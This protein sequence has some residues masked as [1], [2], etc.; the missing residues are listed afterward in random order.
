MRFL[1]AS[2]TTL[3]TV[4]IA[5]E[6]E[7][8]VQE[9]GSQSPMTIKDRASA[10]S[11]VLKAMQS[12]KPSTTAPA[13]ATTTAIVDTTILTTTKKKPVKTTKKKPAKKTTKKKKKAAKT[14]K[15]AAVATPKIRIVQTGV[16][17]PVTTEPANL[18]KRQQQTMQPWAGCGAGSPVT[19][20]Y[21]CV[22]GWACVS[23]NAFYY[24]CLSA[25]SSSAASRTTSA[26]V[27][28]TTAAAAAAVVTPTVDGW[29][30]CGVGSPVTQTYDCNSKC[31]E[32]QDYNGL[33]LGD[34]HICHYFVRPLFRHYFCTGI[35]LDKLQFA[36]CLV[37]RSHIFD[38][39]LIHFVLGCVYHHNSC[40]HRDDIYRRGFDDH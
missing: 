16:D 28:T 40:C 17:A 5:A 3:A 39:Y 10:V 36:F 11:S 6:V 7:Q 37:I 35:K 34:H 27:T 25:T 19:S 26:T 1:L 23:A 12:M 13:L 4:A 14:N 15:K 32:Q 2:L 30:A 8:D 31:I 9:D 29:G 18:Q 22:N 24:Q 38:R 20:T 33:N 21:D